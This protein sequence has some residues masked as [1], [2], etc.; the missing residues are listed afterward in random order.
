[1]NMDKRNKTF[2]PHVS[3]WLT[4]V[5]FFGLLLFTFELSLSLSLTPQTKADQV[6]CGT[7]FCVFFRVAAHHYQTRRSSNAHAF[8]NDSSVWFIF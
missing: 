6:K 5:C 8:M 2:N 7:V 3:Q 1:M 4:V